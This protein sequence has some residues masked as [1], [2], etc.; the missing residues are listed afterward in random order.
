M[1]STDKAAA[2]AADDAAALEADPELRELAERAELIGS[3]DEVLGRHH[4]HIRRLRAKGYPVRLLVAA[5]GYTEQRIYQ[6]LSAD[7]SSRARTPS[8]RNRKR[9][10]PK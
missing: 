1:A 9:R 6:I 4:D 2:L 8:A 7:G 5:T 10:N 3:F